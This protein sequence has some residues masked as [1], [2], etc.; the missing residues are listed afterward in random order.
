MVLENVQPIDRPLGKAYK[1]KLAAFCSNNRHNSWPINVYVSEVSIHF[2]FIYQESISIKEFQANKL[3]PIF[4]VN[5]FIFNIPR[6]AKAGDLVGK[7]IIRIMILM[8]TLIYAF[9]QYI[10]TSR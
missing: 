8:K 2:Y 4:P 3:S 1:F 5:R 10:D 7:V 6:T 9:N